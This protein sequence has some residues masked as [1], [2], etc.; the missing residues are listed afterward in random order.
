[1]RRVI[2]YTAVLFCIFASVLWAQNSK[3]VTDS[4]RNWGQEEVQRYGDRVD[5]G[6]Q[7]RNLEKDPAY[8]A[9]LERYLDKQIKQIKQTNPSKLLKMRKGAKP[10]VVEDSS[11]FT[12][13]GGTKLF[14]TRREQGTGPGPTYYEFKSFTLRSRGT[15]VELWVA[16]DISYPDD[17]ED[18]I[19]QELVDQVRDEFDSNIYP[20]EVELFGQP[21]SLTGE[22]AYLEKY[23]EIEDDLYVSDDGIERVIILVD[24][25]RDNQYYD[26]TY[27]VYQTGFYANTIQAYFDRNI[28][29]LDTRGWNL[30]IEYIYRTLAHEFS[31]L[32]HADR[33]KDESDFINEGIATLTEYLL[34]YD[35]PTEKIDF[36]IN[37]PENSLTIWDD[38][39]YASTG[40]ETLADYGQA[41]L[42]QL[43]LYEKYG[44]KFIIDLFKEPSQGIE[45]INT[46]LKKHKTGIDFKELFKRV[47]IA[48]AIDDPHIFK[49]IY[50]FDTLDIKIQF[51]SA[52]QYNKEGVP[53]WGV[54]Y[55]TLPQ[56]DDLYNIK[57]TGVEFLPL[58]WQIVN[59]PLNGD[60]E[61]LWANN[62][63]NYANDLIMRADLTDATNATIEFD[64]YYD[65]EL[66]YDYAGL[67]I[68][69]D[70]GATWENLL[71][72]ILGDKPGFT[73]KIDNWEH[74]TVD[75]AKY[76]GK[77][78]LI[79]FSYFTDESIVENGW[80]I[81]NI[82]IPEIS[83]TND[84][85][86]VDGLLSKDQLSNTKVDY[87]VTFINAVKSPHDDSKYIHHVVNTAPFNLIGPDAKATLY[88]FFLQGTT[89]MMVWYPA[90]ITDP[91]S[92]IEAPYNY[93]IVN[94]RDWSNYS[95]EEIE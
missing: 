18:V 21:D 81:D 59:D 39:L 86:S 95:P 49:G 36:F 72:E 48:V 17:R 47:S 65:I 53:A 35:H 52:A 28:V 61:V 74:V 80:Y 55:V 58:Q 68:S 71:S 43:Y 4:Y 3:Q 1:M 78:V 38:Q 13:N 22:N 19:N 67:I 14:V 50:N 79:K 26:A 30:N 82:T 63:L 77:K 66:N 40:P 2:S 54:D 76:S 44:E 75:L 8:Q 15:H 94:W 60:N 84:G 24:N 64:H 10:P 23:D 90:P 91:H 37:H 70:N 57:F 34:G 85:S 46:L 5:Y 20:K 88:N 42:L 11:D 32:L 69:V 87:G 41:Y 56:M 12:Y 9:E 51:E 62:R 89:Y 29:T 93:E 83:Y 33:D 73:G 7:I 31:H 25:I 16:D 92:P 6:P 45:S 27:P